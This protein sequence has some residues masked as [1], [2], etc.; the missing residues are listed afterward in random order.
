MSQPR[1]ITNPLH[2]PARVGRTTKRPLRFHQSFD[3]YVPTPLLPLPTA[4]DRLGVAT[5]HLKDESS[6]MGM[7][8]FKILG[9]AWATYRVLTQRLG[10]P[11]DDDLTLAELRDR[12]IGSGLRLCAATDG[13]HGRAVARMATLLGLTAHI[14]VPAD[15]V[16]ERIA[17]I[18]GEGASVEVYDGGYDDAVARSAS[19][20][21]DSTLVVS[22]TSWEGYVDPP[23]WVIDGYSTMI[24]EIRAQLADAGIA[25]PT[26][27]AAQIGVGAFAAAVS[28]GYAGQ[29]DIRLV[30]VEPTQADCMIASVEHGSVTTIPGPQLSMMA[31]L[32]CGTPSPVAWPDVAGGFTHFTT[33]TD[34]ETAEAMRVLHADGVVSG[35]SGAAGLSG[36]LVHAEALGLGPDDSVL[37]VSTE[38]ATD[39]ANHRRIIE[40][41]DAEDTI[42]REG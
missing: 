23:A 32:N 5:V 41:T 40:R 30:G 3:E 34:E 18:E 35:E 6:R 33:V 8:S 11:A 28:R 15:M 37:V 27:V 29:S 10:L 13:N 20:A 17:A 12:L 31:G 7:P 21:D 4:A 14:V 38:G 22:D 25:A 39:E 24:N 26:V 9:A 19:Y 16:A 36:L 2:D 1:C 42:G